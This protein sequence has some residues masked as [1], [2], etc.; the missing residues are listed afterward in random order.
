MLNRRSKD[1]IRQTRV[2]NDA[3]SGQTHST[4]GRDNTAAPVTEE[5][6][7]GRDRHGRAGGQMVRY[8]NIGRAREVRA[9]HH[10]HRCRLREIVQHFESDPNLHPK[11]FP[12]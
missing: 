7:I 9:Q 1:R 3:V 10:D 6:A 2:A 4:D 8:H 5:I 12:N 11:Y